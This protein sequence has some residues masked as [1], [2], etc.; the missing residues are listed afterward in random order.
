MKFLIINGS[1]LLLMLI[2]YYFVLYIIDKRER[3][4]ADAYFNKKHE[5]LIHL[6]RK[7]AINDINNAPVM[8]QCPHCK[9]IMKVNYYWDDDI[10]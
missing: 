4:K 7:H 2:I 1:I 5:E 9:K 10:C 6:A 8:H 3:K